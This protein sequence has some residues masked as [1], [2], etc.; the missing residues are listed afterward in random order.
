MLIGPDLIKQCSHCNNHFLEPTLE[1]CNNIGAIYWT[2]GRSYMPMSPETPALVKCPHCGHILWLDDAPV[3]AKKWS[4]E[5]S[6]ECINAPYYQGLNEQEYLATAQ[7][8]T[9]Y[10]IVRLCRVRAWWAA[11]DRFR[12]DKGE[13]PSSP[14]SE[15]S[16]QNKESLYTLLSKGS[17]KKRL[18]VRKIGI[19][20]GLLRRPRTDVE[21]RLMRAELARE[22]GRFEE[23][24]RLLLTKYYSEYQHLVK[25]I[26]ELANL[27]DVRVAN[28][29]PYVPGFKIG[30]AHL[31]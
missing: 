3:L 14:L 13:V 2:D 7:I 8:N 24:K 16:R 30:R 9:D 27:R 29:E 12:V 28:V 22:L 5:Q 21:D 20:L 31:V 11:N 19:F 17:P 6:S 26:W 18:S 15:E 10:W 4:S 25:R 1:S 23:A